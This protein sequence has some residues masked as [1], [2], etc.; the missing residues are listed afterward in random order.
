MALAA[1]MKRPRLRPLACGT[2]AVAGIEVMSLLAYVVITAHGV[3][4][5]L[6]PPVVDGL[7]RWARDFGAGLI[8]NVI[9]FVTPVIAAVAFHPDLRSQMFPASA[10]VA[11]P[12]PALVRRQS[13]KAGAARSH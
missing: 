3:A 7:A 5:Q 12:S 4:E 13:N 10:E 11:L 8:V 9:P 2:A 6:H 1:S